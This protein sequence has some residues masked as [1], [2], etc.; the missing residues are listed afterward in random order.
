MILHLSNQPDLTVGAVSPNVVLIPMGQNSV[1]TDLNATIMNQ[2]PTTATGADFPYFFQIADNAA[3]TNAQDFPSS[4]MGALNPNGTDIAIFHHT[5]TEGTYYVQAC[6]DK[7]SSAGGS[8]IPES[9]EDNNCSGFTQVQ[10]VQTGT[11]TLPDLIAYPALPYN[12]VA[13]M[14]VN[15]TA[16]IR[17]QG[18]VD[19]GSSF[20]NFFQVQ[21]GGTGSG[22]SGGAQSKSN[23]WFRRIFNIAKAAGGTGGSSGQLIDLTPVQMSHL[24]SN[25]S[26]TTHQNYIFDTAGTYSVRACA[27]KMNRTDAG[28]VNESNENNNCGTWQTITVTPGAPQSKPDLTAGVITPTVAQT[29]QTTTFSA[30]ISNIGA[31]STGGSFTD[32]IQLGTLDAGGHLVVTDAGTQLESALAAGTN[33]T[34][35][36]SERFTHAGSYNARICADKA[37]KNDANGVISESNELNNCGPWTTITVSDEAVASEIGVNLSANKTALTLPDNSVRLSWTTSGSPDSCSA[38]NSPQ[39]LWNGTKNAQGGTENVFGMDSGTYTFAIS[40]KKGTPPNVLTAD[41]TVVVSVYRNPNDIDVTLTSDKTTINPGEKVILDWVTA[42]NPD[43]CIASSIPGT[44]WDGSKTTASGTEEVGGFDAEGIYALKIVCQKGT[45]TKTSTVAVSV[46]SARD[47]LCSPFHFGCLAGALVTNSGSG[48]SASGWAWQCQSTNGSSKINC[49]ESATECA[50]G[51]SNPP[52][53]TVGGCSNGATNPPQC[54]TVG[55]SCMNEGVNPPQCD[56]DSAG[57]CIAVK[58]LNY[59]HPA[60]CKYKKVPVYIER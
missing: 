37:N 54:T 4:T 28:L 6:A 7:S 25:T 39:G 11:G 15:F 1:T 5:F 56:T 51:A 14:P 48:G 35:S 34:L 18:S 33:Y 26:S 31:V 40:C 27:D 30:V 36:I 19:T 45:A 57:N 32:L 53:C 41:S 46:G 13:G 59:Q 24:G 49:T 29:N 12:A 38:S 52:D 9:D 60:P 42:G 21:S 50:N 55:G 43:T 16:T 44:T 22:G 17:N 10:V 2:S 47:V 23:S 3:G 58:A 20:W 8:V